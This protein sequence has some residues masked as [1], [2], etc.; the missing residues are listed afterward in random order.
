VAEFDG[1]VAGGGF[2]DAGHKQFV[3][4]GLDAAGAI[5]E[6]AVG[7]EDVESPTQSSQF[8]TR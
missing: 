6:D 2:E 8:S 5:D 1:F 7:F 3:F 4:G